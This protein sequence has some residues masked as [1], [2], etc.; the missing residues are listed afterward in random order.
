MYAAPENT[1]STYLR[2]MHLLS[3]SC[4]TPSTIFE[5][6]RYRWPT[7][8]I[9]V[10]KTSFHIRMDIWLTRHRVTDVQHHFHDIIP[11]LSRELDH[12]FWSHGFK[13][14]L[15]YYH[16][17]STREHIAFQPLNALIGDNWRPLLQYGCQVVVVGGVF[18]SMC[19]AYSSS[20]PLR[21]SGVSDE[22]HIS[23]I[24]GPD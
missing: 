14:A 11:Y 15:P 1:T 5:S 12:S 7:C 13:R 22:L 8:N 23:S 20:P 24:C 21:N 19:L 17:S 16:T 6:Q 2:F 9:H 18:E 10:V 4:R 3:T